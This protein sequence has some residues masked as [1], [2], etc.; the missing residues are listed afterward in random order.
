MSDIRISAKISHLFDLTVIVLY[1]RI[2]FKIKLSSNTHKKKQTC[3][4]CSAKT[5]HAVVVAT[6]TRNL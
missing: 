5:V 3:F 2:T 6:R 1:F 4:T